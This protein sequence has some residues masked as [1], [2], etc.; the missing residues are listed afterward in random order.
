[1][2]PL[3]SHDVKGCCAC[4][5]AASGVRIAGRLPR[6]GLF[7]RPVHP[8]IDHPQSTSGERDVQRTK[9]PFRADQVGSFLRSE[10]LKEAR[11]KREKGEIGAAD[12]KK[13]EDTEIEK[14]IKKHEEI[15]M[16]Y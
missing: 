15:G 13:V 4:M 12:L 5:A 6:G 3:C 9:P 10:P 16:Q 14:L 7:D 8:C 11:G 1:M 2:F